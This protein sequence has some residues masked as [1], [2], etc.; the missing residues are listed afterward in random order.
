VANRGGSGFPEHRNGLV[1]GVGVAH[2]MT[3][4]D[5]AKL[6]HK[7]SRLITIYY[8]NFLKYFLDFFLRLTYIPEL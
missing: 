5:P 1:H 8:A 2:P 7:L 4:G 6:L 3:R